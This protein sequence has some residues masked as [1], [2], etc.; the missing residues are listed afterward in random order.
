[1]AGEEAVSQQRTQSK[2]QIQRARLKALLPH[3][4]GT[5]ARREIL[6]SKRMEEGEAEEGSE[7]HE[8][9]LKPLFKSQPTLLLVKQT[10]NHSEAGAQSHDCLGCL[11]KSLGTPSIS[12]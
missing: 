11:P 2:F 4:A 1:M 9:V 10:C 3:R 7:T 5:A 12:Q 8:R 6:K